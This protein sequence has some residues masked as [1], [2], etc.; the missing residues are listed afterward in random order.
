MFNYLFIFL[1]LLNTSVTVDYLIYLH[2]KYI[3]NKTSIMLILLIH[4]VIMSLVCILLHVSFS[5]FIFIVSYTT[6]ISCLIF[7]TTKYSVKYQ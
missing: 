7:D 3:L 6:P 5:L 2:N 1:G 4:I